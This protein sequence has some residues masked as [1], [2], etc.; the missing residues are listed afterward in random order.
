MPLTDIIRWAAVLTLGLSCGLALRIGLLYQFG[1]PRPGVTL[2]RLRTL[3]VAALSYAWTFLSGAYAVEVYERLRTSFTIRAPVGLLAG[4]LAMYGM[5]TVTRIVSKIGPVFDR[6]M[7]L[8]RERHE[9]RDLEDSQEHRIG[10]PSASV[11]RTERRDLENTQEKRRVQEDE[12]TY[13]EET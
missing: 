3:H 13:N 11:D 4:L 10:G 12:G 8:D 5:I 6:G 9:R 2:A 7:R 1:R